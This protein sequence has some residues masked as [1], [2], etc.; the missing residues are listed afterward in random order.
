MQVKIFLGCKFI[1]MSR[2][3]FVDEAWVNGLCSVTLF[4]GKV[5]GSFFACG[6]TLR[7]QGLIGISDKLKHFQLNQLELRI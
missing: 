6:I 1:Y 5:T 3:F 2:C 4:L 7:A